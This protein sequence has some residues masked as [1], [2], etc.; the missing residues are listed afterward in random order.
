MAQPRKAWEGSG[1]E[2]SWQFPASLDQ[3]GRISLVKRVTEEMAELHQTMCSDML[4]SD[5]TLP[6]SME[7]GGLVRETS[8]IMSQD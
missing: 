6:V 7:R 3:S 1:V 2:W 8:F 5:H 4:L